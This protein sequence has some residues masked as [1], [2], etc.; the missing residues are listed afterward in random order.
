VSFPYGSHGE[1]NLLMAREQD[2]NGYLRS[3]RS[4]T[5]DPLD[6]FFGRTNPCGPR[7]LEGGIPV[8]SSWFLLVVTIASRMKKVISGELGP[9]I[10]RPL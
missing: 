7:G 6:V 2:T 8:E 1:N 9:N 3:N 4:V 10:E 5:V